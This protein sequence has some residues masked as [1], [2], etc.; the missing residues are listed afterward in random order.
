MYNFSVHISFHWGQLNEFRRYKVENHFFVW[1]GYLYHL[2]LLEMLAITIDRQW[3][4]YLN[5][6]EYIKLS[7]IHRKCTI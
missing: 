4:H 3:S 5:Q 1:L 6:F 2:I 7:E